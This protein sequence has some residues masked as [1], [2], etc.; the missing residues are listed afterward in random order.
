MDAQR[1]KR[2]NAFFDQLYKDVHMCSTL[3]WSLV[4]TELYTGAKPVGKTTKHIKLK[5]KKSGSVQDQERKFQT[6]F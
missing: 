3:L 5:E 1:K 6:L 2:A 4:I